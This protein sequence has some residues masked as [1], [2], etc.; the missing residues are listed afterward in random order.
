[1]WQLAINNLAG[2]RGRT[3]LLILAV[4]LS[5]ALAVMI[6]VVARSMEASMVRGVDRLIGRADLRLIPAPGR[7]GIDLGLRE[8]LERLPG[9]VEVY[10]HLEAPTMLSN[11]DTLEFEAVIARA[12]WPER[13]TDLLITVLIEGRLPRQEGEIALDQLAFERLNARMGMELE[14]EGGLADPVTVVGVFNPP[15]IQLVERYVGLVTYEQA[16]SLHGF[17]DRVDRLEVVLADGIDP[18]E[19]VARHA[20]GLP[21][22]V[23]MQTPMA[24]RAGV[25]QI[26]RAMNYSLVGLIVL[27]YTSSAFIVLITLTT[28]VSQRTRELGILRCIGA[29]RSQ[30]AGGQLLS[31][32]FI[33]AMGAGLGIP[34]GLLAAEQVAS[35]EPA[36]FEM[37]VV[38]RVFDVLGCLAAA[39]FTGLV[40]ALYPAWLASS[41]TPM[42]ALTMRARRPSSRTPWIFLGLGLVMVLIP[43]AVIYLDPDP[44]RAFWFHVFAG[45]PLT[46]IGYLTLCVPV[47]MLLIGVLV[48][49]LA[50]L[51]RVPVDLAR[52]SLLAT[53]VRNALTGGGLMV[54]LTMLIATWAIG[55]GSLGSFTDG[56]MMP[57]V[58]AFAPRI[59]DEQV[60]TVRDIEGV[61]RVCPSAMR[62]VELLNVR[63]GIEGLTPPST[64]FVSFEPECF[65]SIAALD[66]IRGDP[67]TALPRL[68]AGGAVLVSRE[69]RLAFGADVGDTLIV[70]STRADPETGERY[71]VPLQIAGVV[72]NR[73]LDL[74]VQALGM[75][76]AFE[77]VAVAF[78]F[79]SQEDGRKHF[80]LDSYDM[81][82][83]G[84]DPALADVEALVNRIRARGRVEAISGAAVLEHI[85]GLSDSVMWISSFL[86]LASLLIASAGVGNLVAAEIAA[87]RF[88]FGVVRSIGSSRGMIG[89]L[90]VV[91]TIVVALVGCVL[92]TLAGSQAALIRE[93]LAER[94]LGFGYTT[95]PPWD[96]I[97]V[98]WGL[99]LTGALLAAAWPIRRLISRHPRELLAADV[100]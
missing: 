87:R 17:P 28:S 92:G 76:G 32:L 13:E 12:V 43:P 23:E 37:G 47:F 58:F 72:S 48:P 20:A 82:L 56:L 6:S 93:A 30:I 51:M 3:V 41:V 69:Y 50:R 89:R 52:G 38:I 22:G 74:A 49:P 81:L 18:D 65:F 31:G 84:V 63:F 4:A 21:E 10:P 42:K 73:G 59:G 8:W 71:P 79:G 75:Q 60:R 88:E 46:F 15:P 5:A 99:V 35:Q 7:A 97:L 53:P 33:A 14:V 24:A 1:M 90:V 39:L 9:V 95:D 25:T 70:R 96:V 19:F 40:A 68:Q 86:A 16:R 11:P 66:W 91:Q 85:R 100:V 67:E 34:V 61:R 29:A 36:F 64:R 55:R 2:R 80:A 98:G 57:Q 26:L 62:S 78:I 83:I 77:E 45:A 27:V 54:G 44:Q 94:L